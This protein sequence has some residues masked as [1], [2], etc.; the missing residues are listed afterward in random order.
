MQ[1]SQ[2]I[3]IQNGQQ[4]ENETKPPE[5][6]NTIQSNVDQ[7]SNKTILIQPNIDQIYD[8]TSE[9]DSQVGQNL[10]ISN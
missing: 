3:D 6:Q 10:M 5:V 8:Q 2:L 4:L 9:I 7:M 1:I